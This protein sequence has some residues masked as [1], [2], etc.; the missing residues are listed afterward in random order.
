M[1][2]SD[3][4]NP[5]AKP[6]TVVLIDHSYLHQIGWAQSL[7]RAVD[8]VNFI[9]ITD[10]SKSGVSGR[11]ET[12]NIRDVS[13][14]VSLSDLQK[15]YDF[16]IYRTLLTE[17]AYF[18]Y[19]TFN[20][21]QCYSSVDLGDIDRFMSAYATVLDDVIGKR[22]DM[23]FGHLADNAIASLA[24]QISGHYGKSCVEPFV[25]YWWSNGLHFVDRPDQTSIDVDLLYE[26]YYRNPTSID[27]DAIAEVF[28]RPRVSHL[29]ADSAK[30]PLMQ[31]LKKIVSSQNW[32]EPFSLK[33]WIV[34]RL[35]YFCSELLIQARIPILSM[36][37]DN[38]SYVLFP[39]HVAP[40]AALLGP[41]PEMADQFSLIRDISANLPWSVML[42]LKLHPTQQ[43]WSGPDFAFF[44]KITALKN[45]KILRASV[46]L[47]KIL[48]DHKCL[49][50]A[51]I[52]GTVGLEAAMQKKP[53]FV[54]GHAIYGI[55]H[56]FLKPK[57]MQEF[58]E[59]MLSIYRGNFSFDDTAL[60]AI[61]GAIT[62]A[63]WIGKEH[64]AGEKIAKAAVEKT[65]SIIDR[66]IHSGV[67]KLTG[68]SRLDV[69]LGQRQAEDAPS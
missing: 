69:L 3:P 67:W 53:V 7:A 46:P 21:A 55:A 25:Y 61:L 36:I 62:Q 41:D 4:L 15:K 47:S 49:A 9:L 40:E 35:R 31:R 63:V 12:I 66:Y 8:G 44:K 2:S 42:Y 27:S 37:S 14:P 39:L 13:S 6:P 5:R 68:A 28:S 18:D 48:N 26:H 50:V 59:Q 17:R 24:A 65:F 30:Y 54:F 16:S 33:N 10:K 29:Y 19:T 57:S 23:V 34:R 43:K 51:T 11:L 1:I 32:Y 38:D 22:A 45:V 20:N 58:R 52:N 64:Y 60:K 56:C